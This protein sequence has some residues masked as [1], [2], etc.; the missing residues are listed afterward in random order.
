MSVLARPGSP[1][2]TL[3]YLRQLRVVA[4]RRRRFGVER[5]VVVDCGGD[6]GDTSR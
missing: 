4:A 1:A 3:A 5:M 6:R 2:A